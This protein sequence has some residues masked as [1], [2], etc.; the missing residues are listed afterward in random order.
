MKTMTT[1][2][3]VIALSAIGAAIANTRHRKLGVR[4][5][6]EELEVYLNFMAELSLESKSYGD[7]S[8][9]YSRPSGTKHVES[10]Q[11]AGCLVGNKLVNY[12]VVEKPGGLIQIEFHLSDERY[13]FE[14]YV[15]NQ[16]NSH[17]EI[18]LKIKMVLEALF[19]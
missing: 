3:R 6:P 17:S 10:N 1:A 15:L 18:T 2:K 4:L 12:R 11:L 14:V 8:L 19:G 13:P 9:E 16:E 5:T 7:G